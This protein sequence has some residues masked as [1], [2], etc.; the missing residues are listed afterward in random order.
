MA[1]K[2]HTP[3]YPESL[4]Q[5]QQGSQPA[6]QDGSPHRHSKRQPGQVKKSEK[7]QQIQFDSHQ[8][9]SSLWKFLRCWLSFCPIFCHCARAFDSTKKR[10]GLPAWPCKSV[11]VLQVVDGHRHSSHLLPP[12]APEGHTLSIRPALQVTG[13][14][15]DRMCRAEPGGKSRRCHVLFAGAA[16]QGTAGGRSSSDCLSMYK[17]WGWAGA[18]PAQSQ[19]TEEV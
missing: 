19:G 10:A 11:L 12:K 16:I 2:T 18:A 4:S 1:H 8:I 3:L 7:R 9:L 5:L 14:C 13:A 15:L 6:S 17:E